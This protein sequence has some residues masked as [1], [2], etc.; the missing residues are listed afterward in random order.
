MVNILRLNFTCI[1]IFIFTFKRSE[2]FCLEIPF[3]I[4]PSGLT[5]WRAR[6]I[7]AF[8]FTRS[9]KTT[10]AVNFGAKEWA[11]VA[12]RSILDETRYQFKREEGNF[13][14][15]HVPKVNLSPPSFFSYSCPKD[16]FCKTGKSPRTV[17]WYNR[18]DNDFNV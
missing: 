18:L 6:K 1:T 2:S 17:I 8:Q 9:T 4:T 16:V 5:A 11:L 7:S 15:L 3:L 14:N 12:Q 10:H 13:S